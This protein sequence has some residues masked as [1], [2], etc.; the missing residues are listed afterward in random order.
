M[1]PIDGDRF[2]NIIR[3]MG[4]MYGAEPDGLVLDAYWIALSDWNLEDFQSAAQRLM[5]T[6]KFMPRPSDWEELRRA[7]RMTSGEAFAKAIAWAKTGAYKHPAI[8][9]DAVMIDRVVHAMGGW[10]RVTTH[11]AENLQWLEKSFA[12]HYE[13]IQDV[14]DTREALP[15]IAGPLHPRIAAGLK[16]L[17]QV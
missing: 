15:Q 5:K 12:E 1:Q 17:E 8:T 9:P 11:D 6:S 16:M 4:R 13:T 14:T 10:S 3:G 7:G 2:R